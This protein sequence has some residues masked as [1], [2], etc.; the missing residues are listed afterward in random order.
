[1]VSSIVVTSSGDGAVAH[2]KL[3]LANEALPHDSL[4]LAALKVANCILAHDGLELAIGSSY[5]P[6]YPSI[7]DGA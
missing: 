3:E 6:S 5:S 7:K 2:D 4:K 1:M